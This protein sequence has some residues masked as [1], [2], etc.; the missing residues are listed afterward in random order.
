MNIKK[1]LIFAAAFLQVFAY[2]DF[3]AQDL[4][5]KSA[6]KVD[7][8][9]KIAEANEA[10]IAEKS[11]L[12]ARLAARLSLNARI[13]HDIAEA[14]AESEKSQAAASEILASIEKFKSFEIDLEKS[15]VDFTKSFW[16]KSQKLPAFYV[17][18]G[19]PESGGTFKDV[20]SFAE[21]A[22]EA[23]IFALKSSRELSAREIDGEEAVFIGIC[24]ALKKSECAEVSE[25]IDI[26]NG[27]SAH[28]IISISVE[29]KGK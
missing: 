22:I 2:A 27:R 15:L 20:Y 14:K 13:K 6:Q 29:R 17:L 23:R 11:E 28:K 18:K 5:E 16:E 12:E 4:M 9:K 8:L 3:S 7:I 25:I 1:F 26:L 19:A 24:A 21:A 10:W